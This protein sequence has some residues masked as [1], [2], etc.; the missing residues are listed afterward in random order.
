MRPSSLPRSNAPAPKKPSGV[1]TR[2]A[3]GWLALALAGGP[4]FGLYWAN[5]NTAPPSTAETSQITRNLAAAPLTK[6]AEVYA[7]IPDEF[8]DES[9]TVVATT[10]KQIQVADAKRTV[11]VLRQI[12]P[13]LLSNDLTANNPKQPDLDL[14]H[15]C[16]NSIDVVLRVLKNNPQVAAGKLY[17]EGATGT[18]LKA[19]VEQAYKMAVKQRVSESGRDK[20]L[21]GFVESQSNPELRDWL[22]AHMANSAA[23]R[24]FYSGQMQPMLTEPDDYQRTKKY[25]LDNNVLSREELNSLQDIFQIFADPALA[26]DSPLRTNFVT[27]IGYFLVYKQALEEKLLSSSA[28]S[29]AALLKEVKAI[30][31]RVQRLDDTVPLPAKAYALTAHHILAGDYKPT[32]RIP[33]KHL[34]NVYKEIFKEKKQ[35]ALGQMAKEPESSA[36]MIDGA[37]HNWKALVEEWNRTNPDDQCNLIEISPRELSKHSLAAKG[38][39]YEQSIEM[40]MQGY[41]QLKGQFRASFEGKSN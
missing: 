31:E 21:M 39:D 34:A 11:I 14:V 25:L 16:Q 8:R 4:A 41:A 6:A 2:K 3:L 15:P 37:I 38:F 27:N 26:A 22:K 19:N 23:H 40:M 33:T 18:A 29:K 9:G 20:Y 30:L 32:S 5:R 35:F 10:K 36:L 28:E 12:H 24:Q 7:A 17:V 1:S 13:E